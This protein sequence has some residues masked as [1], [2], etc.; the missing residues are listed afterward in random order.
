MQKG[1]L[2]RLD[3]FRIG[4]EIENEETRRK[5]LDLR[6]PDI[7]GKAHFL[8]NANKET[9]GEIATHFVDQLESITVRIKNIGAAVPYDQDRLRLFKLGFYYLCLRQVRRQW[10]GL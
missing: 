2:H 3:F 5:G 9:R 1:A 4:A 7:I 6:G 8:A 10:R